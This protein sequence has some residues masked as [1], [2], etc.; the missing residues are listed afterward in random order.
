[1]PRLD[2]DEGDSSAVTPS[3][4]PGSPDV[5]LAKPSNETQGN[6]LDKSDHKPQA[7]MVKGNP[8]FTRLGD[9]TP[10]PASPSPRD[11]PVTNG[12]ANGNQLGPPHPH[13]KLAPTSEE[14][15]E[16]VS[17]LTK[18]IK[19]ASSQAAGK[20]LQTSWRK[21]LFSENDQDHLCWVLRAGLKNAP[22]SV[23]ARILSDQSI[24][25]TLTPV[26]SK[27]ETLIKA[28]LKDA[29][30]DQL[31]SYLPND[32]LDREICQRLKT[33]PATL[34]IKW[35]AESERLGFRENDI[36]NE[37]DET[38]V[39]NPAITMSG[40][41]AP[42]ELESQLSHTI[43]PD[44]GIS[45][46]DSGRSIQ[47]FGS[48]LEMLDGEPSALSVANVSRDSVFAAQD[49]QRQQQ[50]QHAAAIAP[51][52]ANSLP[53]MCPTCHCVFPS[54]SGY[55]YVCSVYLRPHFISPQ[56]TVCMVL[57]LSQHLF[58]KI[59]SKP[60][61]TKGY[62]LR[63]ENC[64]QSFT[65]RQGASYV[66]VQGHIHWPKT[67]NS[68]HELNSVCLDQGTAPATSPSS[69]PPPILPPPRQS[70]SASHQVQNGQVQ[71]PPNLYLQQRN[72]GDRILPPQPPNMHLQQRKSD[73]PILP[74]QR[75]TLSTPHHAQNRP[76]Q[77]SE[78]SRTGLSSGTSIPRPPLQTPVASQTPLNGVQRSTGS[79]HRLS[80]S[81]LD[82]HAL[83]ELNKA[84]ADQELT[85]QRR[86]AAIDPS[87][88][89][90]E[91]AAKLQT[92]KNGHASRKSQIRKSFNVTLRLGEKDKAA[93]NASMT[94]PIP[95]P[96]LEGYR[97][98]P[99][100]NNGHGKPGSQSMSK[101]SPANA[102]NH[103]AFVVENGVGLFRPSDTSSSFGEHQPH[104]N[105]RQRT[106]D[107]DS[108][109]LTYTYPNLQNRPQAQSSAGVADRSS[110]LGRRSMEV[111]GD[112]MGGV[113]VN[114]PQTQ[115]S[116]ASPGGSMSN[117]QVII[118]S[119]ESSSESSGEDT[120]IP[121]VAAPSAS[122]SGTQHNTTTN[123]NERTGPRRNTGVPTRGTFTAK[124]GRPY[125]HRRF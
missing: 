40:T 107:S 44:S 66:G 104:A 103:S 93:R 46:R 75:P 82:P 116:Q 88:G 122:A 55:N 43:I 1:M 22:S 8:L 33:M 51:N 61:P 3:R 63:C 9:V 24:I 21:F 48:D 97:A 70:F 53:L 59:C 74:P 2:D 52:G 47:G 121:S 6:S 110:S 54:N 92:L 109:M 42:T 99:L 32:V 76:T 5:V 60:A 106:E 15:A 125:S 87:L 96:N 65:T 56:Y 27:Q 73:D 19:S 37:E 20:V 102:M 31:L 119:G 101:S 58:K 117:V 105:K 25:N 30:H 113:E 14:L 39:P 4:S 41:P 94:T 35:L 85:Y 95:R 7:N 100:H 86:C 13:P 26:A 69:Q 29:T 57:T 84:L 10:L 108:D 98:N 64:G 112:R 12:A 91:R 36:I 80:P 71:P 17:D 81:E 62:I 123:A 83:A 16:E 23:I 89:P 114:K 49:Q 77:Q 118:S 34:L 68:K 45:E 90:A 11:T 38:V 50:Q 124:R 120:D 67:D 111:H 115:A 78:Q 18:I 28:V 72:S 79:Q